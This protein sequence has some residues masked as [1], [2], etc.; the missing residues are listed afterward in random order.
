MIIVE[1][2]ILITSTLLKRVSIQSKCT[3][4]ALPEGLSYIYKSSINNQNQLTTTTQTTRSTT[5]SP[6]LSP[7]KTLKNP[8]S[9][10]LLFHFADSYLARISVKRATTAGSDGTVSEGVKVQRPNAQFRMWCCVGF[11]VVEVEVV[12]W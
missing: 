12:V 4:L 1:N 7:P 8:P 11:V 10:I 5:T 3:Y 2:R 9:S 6:F